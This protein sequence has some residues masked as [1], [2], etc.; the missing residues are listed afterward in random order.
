MPF[1]M[2]SLLLH[3]LDYFGDLSVGGAECHGGQAILSRL[4][5]HIGLAVIL[6]KTEDD[7]HQAHST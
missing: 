6:A 2:A 7:I 1:S 5:L 4:I 3:A